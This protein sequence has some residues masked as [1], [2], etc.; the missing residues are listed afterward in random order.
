M[1]VQGVILSAPAPAQVLETPALLAI[2]EIRVGALDHDTPGLWAGTGLE[3]QAADANLEVL[4][5][6]WAR[7]FGGYLRPA[8]GATINFGGDTSKV[9]ADLRWEI[10]APSGV[11]FALG[12]GAALHDGRLDPDTPD[13]KALGSPVLFHPSV[14]LGYR[15]AGGTSI[16]IFADHISNGYSRRNNDGMDTIGVR[17]GY[18]FGP[19]AMEEAVAE[20]PVASF[21]GF[22]VGALAGYSFEQADWFTGARS[23]AG[24]A[25]A[26]S[27]AAVA[28]YNWQS[29]NG[30]FGLEVDASPLTSDLSTSCIG[31]AI[32]CQ[33]EVSGVYSVR[34]RFGWVIGD[35]M[36]YGT[37]GL[38][39][40]YWDAGVTN[41]ATSAQLG[42]VSGINYGV[43][44]GGGIE[45][46][47]GPHFGVRAEIM[48]YGIPGQDVTVTGVGTVTNQF[49]STV[50]RIGLMW[51]F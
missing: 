19:L 32:T 3:R 26:F 18:R 6:P 37:G 41:T 1:L 11:F 23:R 24:P 5:T 27:A 20:M 46:K 7:A 28:G 45:Y 30:V 9:Y 48:H 12:M 31:P 47:L 14:E 8:I 22:Y 51:H 43:A 40:A 16:S 42:K 36:I 50:G 21:S 25:G 13:R 10:G 15:F 2:S 34:P 38:A 17:L 44:V 35:A 4:F 29:G 49:Q 39:L 33:M